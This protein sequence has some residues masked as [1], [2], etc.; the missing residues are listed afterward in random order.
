MSLN[1]IKPSNFILLCDTYKY[2]HFA[3]Y[4][5][6]TAA[7]YSTVVPRKASDYTDEIVAAGAAFA[8]AYLASVT[9]T[10]EMIDEAEAE[11]N[12]SGY[13]FNRAGWE[14]ILHD[15][16]GKLPLAM[17]GV[18]EGTVVKPNTPILG[19]VN[20]DTRLAWLTSY[21]ET[22]VQRIMWKMTTVA[23][24]SRY[25]YKWID[26]SAVFTGADRGMVEWR[27][28]NFGDRGADGEDGAIMAAMS[29]AMLFS[30]SDCGSVNRYIK[31]IYNTTR[32]YTASVDAT[33]HSVMCSHSDSENKDDF[34]AA[35]MAVGRLEETVARTKRGIGIPLQSVVID[36]YD[37]ERFVREY[38]GERLKERI[39][40]SGGV[41]VAR[42]D[43]GDPIK[44]PIQVIQ[45]LEEKFGATVNAKGYKTL[46]PAVRV[47]QGDGINERSIPQIIGQLW[48]AGY[49]MDNLVFGMGGGL[50]HGGSRDQFSFSMKATARFGKD[51]WVDLLKEPKSDIGKKSL[52]G[53][54]RTRWDE[55]GNVE[56]FKAE[57][58]V[59]CFNEGEGW[60][61]YYYNGQT[62]YVP[63]FD[64]VRARARVG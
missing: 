41:L 40:A 59:E 20:N 31:A 4:P 51:G 8:A 17:F 11:I 19:I 21:V 28:H 38:L 64:E 37:D 16:D 45:W 56:T 60:Q 3:E 35:V 18:E 61:L 26:K 33:E 30:G 50:T 25:L 24:Q 13:E 14:I 27:L 43:S 55:E 47:I 2:H 63:N 23:S 9:I 7:I 29:H 39:L 5:E 62:R 44:K 57:D 53:L 58:A 42:P 34:G 36:T 6:D 22:V 49:S 32:N 10:Q 15:H 52:K 12:G 46:N 54:V 1:A 48:A